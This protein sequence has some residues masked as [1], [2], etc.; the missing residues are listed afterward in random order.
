MMQLDIHADLYEKIQAQARL[1]GQTVEEWL[2][3]QTTPSQSVDLS[4]FNAWF[5][6]LVSHDLRTPL[7][8]IMTSTEILK[9]YRARLSDERQTEHLNTVQMQVRTLNNLLDNVMVVQ[10]YAAGTL[11]FDPAP[12]DLEAVCREA[13]EATGAVVYKNVNFSFQVD[14]TLP[15]VSYDEKLLLLALT[16]VL[17]NAVEYSAEGDL[18]EVTLATSGGQAL[19]QV[20][21]NGIGI[22]P[23]EQGQVFDLFYRASNVRA[24]NGHGLGL[25]VVQRI[26]DL[27]KGGVSISSEPGQ[28]T[29]VTISLPLP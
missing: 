24:Y 7:A 8:A 28:G 16:N 4:E 20:R 3:D 5:I 18:I 21:D 26:I 23:E 11:I 13:V 19:I 29:T 14:G 1:S 12:Q 25:A 9:Y 2:T 22:P 10:K 15:A 6:R 17:I 27:H